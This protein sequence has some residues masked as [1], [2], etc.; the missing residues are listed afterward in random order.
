MTR[1]S[2]L[3]LSGSARTIGKGGVTHNTELKILTQCYGSTPPSSIKNTHASLK[4]ILDLYDNLEGLD[5]NPRDY[6]Y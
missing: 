5:S 2:S 4:H 6:T 1:E 3:A